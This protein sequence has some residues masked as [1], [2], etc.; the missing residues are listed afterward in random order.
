ML[1]FCTILCSCR[2]DDT[3]P[4]DPPKLSPETFI[5]LNNILYTQFNLVPILG[6]ISSK[7]PGDTRRR[8]FN[9]CK[10]SIRH[11]RSRVDVLSTLKRRHVSTGIM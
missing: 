11:G 2:M 3:L 1:V 9:V 8:V 7:F 4:A 10:T 6:M 5:T